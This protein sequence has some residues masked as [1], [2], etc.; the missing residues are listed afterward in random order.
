MAADLDRHLRPFPVTGPGVP[1]ERPY[2]VLPTSDWMPYSWSINNVVMGEVQHT[3]LAYWQ[4]G[5][6]ETAYELAKGAVLASLYM[7]ITPGNIGTM[8]Y[9]DV[10]RRE[11]QRDFADGAGVMS[12]MMVEGLFGL[13]PDAQ[14]GTLTG[15]PHV[16][17]ALPSQGLGAWAGHVNEMAVIDDAGLRAQGGTLRLANG[18][19][20]ATP[21]ASGVDN[22]VFTSQ[23]DNYPRQAVIPLQGRGA[24]RFC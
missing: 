20:F 21:A 12:R 22:V 14:A 4:A 13:Q 9:L 19:S 6:A 17:L 8:N 23:W 2:R 16:S 24:E 5:R 11:A 15:S 3:A 7:G 1:A 18:L 10:Y